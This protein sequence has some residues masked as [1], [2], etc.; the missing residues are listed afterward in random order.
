M[1]QVEFVVVTP[2]EA[3]QK[4]LQFLQRRV[5]KEVPKSAIMR[6]IRTGQVRLN[7]GRVKPF[8]RL[9][10]DDIV[11]IPPYTVDESALSSEQKKARE[12][13]ASNNI[14]LNIVNESDGLLVLHKPAGLPVQPGTGHQ[15]AVTTRLKIQY[16]DAPFCPTPAHRLDKNTSGL[17][18][19]ATSYTRLQELHKLFR[20]EHA[21]GK[22]YLAWVEGRWEHPE[23][24]Q[25]Y[26][27][28]SKQAQVDGKERMETG[29]GKESLCT[30]TPLLVT[31]KKSLLHISLQTGRTHQI[32]V[33]LSSRNHPIIGDT[34][35]GASPNP[36]GMLLH[37]WR[38]ILPTESFV[39]MPTWKSPFF[40][41]N[42]LVE[43]I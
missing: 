11:R 39:C 8:V 30:V 21:L 15:D 7:K 41:G 23:T 4:L 42:E 5:D 12:D 3:G 28:L 9:K 35:Y 16:V 22:H 10:Q 19:V 34:K 40:V 36:Q 37:A 26:D 18:L 17:L 25:L 2:E 43:T 29:N 31:N 6:W 32:R 1:G 20:N 33:Q 13:S 14:A 38:I 24:V 27:K